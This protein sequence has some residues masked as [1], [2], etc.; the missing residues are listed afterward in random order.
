MV[1]LRRRSVKPLRWNT[2][3][4]AERVS[5]L[6]ALATEEQGCAMVG[7]DEMWSL[8]VPAT[9]RVCEAHSVACRLL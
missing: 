5:C 9:S 6:I 2:I 8:A 3:A 4:F 7:R 1:S